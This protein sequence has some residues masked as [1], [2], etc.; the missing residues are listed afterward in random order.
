MKFLKNILAIVIILVMLGSIVTADSVNMFDK[1][2]A[3]IGKYVNWDNGEL[4]DNLQFVASDYIP[5]VAGQQYNCNKLNRGMAYYNASKQ[6]ISGQELPPNTFTAPTGAVYVRVTPLAADI[7][8]FEMVNATPTPTPTPAPQPDNTALFLPDEICVAVGRTIEL[9]NSQVFLSGNIDNYHFKWDCAVGKAL[10]R[11]FSITGT[12]DLLGWYTLN[13]TVYD[14]NLNVVATDSTTLKVVSNSVATKK[15]LTIGDSLT[16]SKAWLNELGVLS[17]N[18]YSM[19]GTLGTTVKHEGRTGWS[20]EKYLTD[21]TSPFWNGTRFSWSH[22][23][24]TT[25]INPDA[26]QIFLG[27]NGMY[28]DPT[29]NANN[30]KQIVDYIRQ[31][32]STLPIFV[33]NTLYRGNQNGIGNETYPNGQAISKG[34][35]KYEE[36]RKVF[37]LMV[38][39]DE[40]IG[41]YTN[42][43]FVPIA[44]CHDSEYNFGAVVTPVNPRAVQTEFMPIEGTHPQ[45]QGYM[46]M[47]D[48]MFSTFAAH[49]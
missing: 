19:V 9:Y 42:L 47:A 4:W 18:K 40:L 37:N 28:L 3:S 38:K 43:Y 41:S 44:T 29:G 24:S 36:D 46:Q 34:Q 10:D 17:S 11:K 26:V 7:D 22:Y 27:T 2:K 1:T 8:T 12:T 49:L 21:T 5:V 20:A 30:I 35:F 32:D 15:I 23:K 33:V 48:I 14:N 45:K 16:D 39:L 31:D 13:L 6:F 25:G